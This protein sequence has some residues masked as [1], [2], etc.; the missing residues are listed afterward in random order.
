MD[1]LLRLKTP[2]EQRRDA[3]RELDF[4]DRQAQVALGDYHRRL[5]EIDRQ[6]KRVLKRLLAIRQKEVNTK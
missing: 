2:A 3:E 6:R 1:E 4:L 5:A